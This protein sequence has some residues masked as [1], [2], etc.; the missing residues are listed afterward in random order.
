MTG[1][2][3]K[4]SLMVL[5]KIGVGGSDFDKGAAPGTELL[6]RSVEIESKI[7]LKTEG[8]FKMFFF[9]NFSIRL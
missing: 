6:A 3:P 2:T 5:I 8:A 1:P 9:F 4:I 7:E